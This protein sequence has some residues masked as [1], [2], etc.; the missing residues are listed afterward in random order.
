MDVYTV[1][2]YTAWAWEKEGGRASDPKSSND[3]DVA[4]MIQ[5]GS[6]TP[7]YHIGG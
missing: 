5:F 7:S 6:I 1:L 4:N 3:V 2:H